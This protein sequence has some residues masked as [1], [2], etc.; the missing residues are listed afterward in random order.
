MAAAPGAAE[1]VRMRRALLVAA[2]VL[3][4]A[5]HARAGVIA[6]LSSDFTPVSF[7]AGWQYLRNTGP[8]ET[9]PN[10]VPLVWH[11]SLSIYDVDGVNMPAPGFDY[12]LVSPS[13]SHPGLGTAQGSSFDRY[14]VLAYTLQPGEAGSVEVNGGIAGIDPGGAG[15]ASNGWDIRTFVGSS[16]IGGPLTFPWFEHPRL[17]S[18]QLGVLSDGET[19]YVALG[20]SGNHLFD[21]AAFDFAISSTPVE[22][23]V[24]EPATT[25]LA[26]GL[27]AAFGAR[28]RRL[29]RRSP[30]RRE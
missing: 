10:Y 16:E 9:V 19:V 24:P 7:P 1:E 17:F 22:Q 11:S 25:V 28:R 18:R 4:G 21:A 30:T 26:L 8:I 3:L 12:T 5:V 15:G 2:L 23:P 29:A 20:P 6:D 13:V 14:L 27:A